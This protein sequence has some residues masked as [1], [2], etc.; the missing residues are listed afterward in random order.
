M[1]WYD[2]SWRDGYDAWKTREPDYDEPEEEGCD[3]RTREKFRYCISGDTVVFMC[4]DCID[5]AERA[6]HADWYANQP[7]SY[8]ISYRWMVF[9][10]WVRWHSWR[11]CTRP[12]RAVRSWWRGYRKAPWKVDDDVPF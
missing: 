10:Q 6:E 1:P 7:L 4:R 3:C 12:F 9:R 2:D 11:E 5:E 8:R